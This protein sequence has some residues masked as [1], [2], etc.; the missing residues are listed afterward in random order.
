MAK[1][2]KNERHDIDV[3]QPVRSPS[4]TTSPSRG[5]WPVGTDHAA[6]YFGVPGLKVLP[7]GKQYAN[8]ALR[9]HLKRVPS[10]RC[11]GPLYPPTVK[12]RSKRGWTE[13]AVK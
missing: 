10:L 11:I 3:R 2:K 13:G 6:R 8:E 9:E 1:A 7:L 4:T 12:G 5:G